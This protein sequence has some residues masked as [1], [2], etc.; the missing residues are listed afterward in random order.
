MGTRKMIGYAGS[1]LILI[2][3]F[4][5]FVRVPVL[6]GLNI[7][8]GGSSVGIALLVLAVISMLVVAVELFKAL[9]FSGTGILMILIFAIG[10]FFSKMREAKEEMTKA[11][12]FKAMG[13]AI[14]S[15]VS[16]DVGLPIMALGI[17]LL[18][19]CALTNKFGG[20]GSSEGSSTGFSMPSFSFELKDDWVMTPAQAWVIVGVVAVLTMIAFLWVF[21][22]M[23]RAGIR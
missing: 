6:G 8:G 13:E 1:S 7:F 15:S 20:A 3:I 4:L 23:H 12:P 9:L 17:V 10:G 2:G 19:Y 16:I 5:P 18:Y 21:P 14:I 22:A 11:G